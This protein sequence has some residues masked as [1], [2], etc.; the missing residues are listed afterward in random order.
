MFPGI[1]AGNSLAQSRSTGEAVPAAPGQQPRC[2]ACSSPS[3]AAWL[4]SLAG[5]PWQ[6][7]PGRGTARA[8]PQGA[9]VSR[10][11]R[12]ASPSRSTRWC[13][14]T[15]LL[16][17]LHSAGGQ[18][19]RTLPVVT[20]S[21]GAPGE[22]PRA[23]TGRPH[24][25]RVTRDG[26]C[27]Q[28]CPRRGAALP[29]GWTCYSLRQPGAGMRCPGISK[30]I[31]ISVPHICLYLMFLPSGGCTSPWSPRLQQTG[32]WGSPR[33]NT[34]TSLCWGPV[35]SEGCPRPSHGAAQSEG[36]TSS[37]PCLG[38]GVPCSSLPKAESHSPA[39]ACCSLLHTLLSTTEALFHSPPQGWSF[40]LG[41][42]PGKQHILTLGGGIRGISPKMGN[43]PAPEIIVV[44]FNQNCLCNIP[45]G[46][47]PH[48]SCF[49]PLC[50]LGAH[51]VAEITQCRLSSPIQ[52]HTPCHSRQGI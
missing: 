47:A 32:R 35:S 15:A 27:R 12:G 48:G 34:V 14:K 22:P 13:C 37:S 4:A 40:R 26:T 31:N 50:A 24:A 17:G 46:A 39:P 2:A 6:H 21:A 11:E 52:D 43:Q 30:G 7:D 41:V 9:A 25:R 19:G 44:W 42:S 29:L 38:S 51:S 3:P 18:A 49:E 23:S 20:A 16:P 1:L 36:S 5:W 45:A 33:P 10:G 8:C 28:L